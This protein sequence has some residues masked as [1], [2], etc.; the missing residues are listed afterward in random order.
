[1]NGGI[2]STLEGQDDQVT[3]YVEVEV[4]VLGD[5]VHTARLTALLTTAKPTRMSA[6]G[7]ERTSEMMRTE[8]MWI[9]M[10]FI[11]LSADV[12]DPQVG[13]RACAHRSILHLGSCAPLRPCNSAPIVAAQSTPS[14]ASP[15][16][17]SCKS[18][19]T[20]SYRSAVFMS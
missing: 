18:I 8:N 6:L 20:A 13:I 19:P 12:L 3:A 11:E 2:L 7:I 16:R 15:C 5:P 1:M 4:A 17:S 14:C 9:T 10:T